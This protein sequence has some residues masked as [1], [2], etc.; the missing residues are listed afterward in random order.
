MP[1]RRRQLGSGDILR[2][3]KAQ[4]ASELLAVQDLAHDG[5]GMAE[6]ARGALDV[7][8]LERRPRRRRGGGLR[9][10][11]P[12]GGDPLDEFD[13]EAMAFA[14]LL[15][16]GR[17][18]HAPRAEMEII[19]GDD[20]ADAEAAH[21]NLADELS[22]LRPASAA[23]KVMTIMPSRPRRARDFAFVRIGASR[24][25]VFAPRKKSLG[26]GSNVS[27]AQGRPSFSASASARR[28]T[29]TWPRWRPS[30]LPIATTAPS[31]PA[32]GAV[33][34]MARMKSLRAGNRPMEPD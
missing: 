18:P 9:R 17:R 5:E 33:G 10:I 34:S 8:R 13:R 19:T 30:K 7:A 28:I 2:V 22:A 14:G 25:I 6:Q 23:S 31:S 3:G 16:E 12:L 20:G 32:G 21:Q 15:Q 26:C 4:R 11:A 27:T 29:A 1:W 24:K